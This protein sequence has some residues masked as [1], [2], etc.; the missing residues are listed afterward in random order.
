MNDAAGHQPFV[1]ASATRLVE[2]LSNASDVRD[3]IKMATRAQTEDDIEKHRQSLLA[4]FTKV[5]DHVIAEIAEPYIHYASRVNLVGAYQ[6]IL[7]TVFEDIPGF[8][9]YGDKNAIWV[10]TPIEQLAFKLKDF[11]HEVHVLRG[12]KKSLL[13]AVIEA[14]KDI[15]LA[16]AAYPAGRP[17]T[18]SLDEGST[19]SLLADWG[20]DNPAAKHIAFVAGNADPKPKMVIHLGDIY[21]GG[22]KAECEAFLRNWPLQGD[23]KNP[24]STIPPGSSFALNG[25]HEMYSGGEAFFRVILP[26]FGQPQPFFCLEGEHWRLI[27]LDTAYMDGRLKPPTKDDP[28]QEQWQWLINL[29]VNGPKRANIFLTHHQ[30]VSAHDAEFRASET[31]R[32]DVCELLATAGIKHDAIY[33]WFFG[34]EHRFTIYRDDE[35]LYNARLIGS[36]C[37]PHEIQREVE[38]DPGCTPFTFVSGRGVDDSVTAISQFAELRFFGQRL[39][40]NYRDENGVSLGWEM[41]D[42]TRSRLDPERAFVA[43]ETS[44]SK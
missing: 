34:H 16:K 43:D 29:L 36:G 19:V 8:Q 4:D 38:P 5:R 7:G 31:L 6:S 2:H 24:G 21:Y 35:T 33:A 42:S 3:A 11:F 26:A 10:I 15:K 41:W 14:W 9:G 27:G 22:I 30:P 40:V 12:A 23:P 37:I 18:L 39:R 28:M 17:V 25:N 1:R 20:G 44:H 32:S 13:Q